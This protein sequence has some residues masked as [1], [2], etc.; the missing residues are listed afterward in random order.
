MRVQKNKNILLY[1]LVITLILMGCAKRQFIP[2]PAR[3]N[4]ELLPGYKSVLIVGCLGPEAGEF[5]HPTGIALDKKGNIYV[6]DTGNHR[7]Q[8][9]N[10]KGQ[11]ISSFGGIEDGLGMLTGITSFKDGLLVV[12]RSRN[13]LLAFTAKGRPLNYDFSKELS[14]FE[15]LNQVARSKK[16]KIFGVEGD[17]AIAIDRDGDFL[18]TAD[19]DKIQKF[20]IN[21]DGE[22]KLVLEFGGWGK[23]QGKLMLPQGIDVDR[24][25]YIYVADTLNGRIQKFSPR[26]KFLLALGGL[27]KPMGV[28][29]TEIGEIWVVENGAHRL[30]KF[31]PEIEVVIPKEIAGENNYEWVYNRGRR[32]QSS[33]MIYHAIAYY[34]RCIEIKSDS[35]LAPKAQL[36]IGRSFRGIGSNE[37]AFMAY[38]QVVE[39]YP[40]SREAPRALLEKGELLEELGLF[41]DARRIYER[42]VKKYPDSKENKRAEERIEYIEEEIL[43]G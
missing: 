31:V 2:S 35:P 33:G 37:A 19:I 29:V 30:Q 11:V 21:K 36:Q 25:G 41:G 26:G 23:A 3:A 8:G 40:G 24:Q 20:R 9:F 10:P 34:K 15:D 1:Y 28:A 7:I 6:T 12:D 5:D 39:D 43:G 18:Y 42:L 13:L 14:Q 27:D 38:E 16:G 22:L 17:R 4:K 32:F